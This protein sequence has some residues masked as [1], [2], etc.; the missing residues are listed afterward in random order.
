[1]ALLEKCALRDQS[2][3]QPQSQRRPPK[4]GRYKFKFNFNGWRSRFA[5]PPLP[6]QL[7]RRRA[8]E[9]PALLVQQL[10]DFCF[11]F[12]LLEG[13]ALDFAVAFGVH[14]EFCAQDH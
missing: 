2:Q 13:L 9:T 14:Q 1:M 11:D 6:P 10:F 8:G 3:I 7:Q 5:G 12:G 4:G